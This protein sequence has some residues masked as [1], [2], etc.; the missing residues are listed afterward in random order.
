MDRE[1]EK[2]QM[3]LITIEDIFVP[4]ERKRKTMINRQIN[5]TTRKDLEIK[6]TDKHKDKQIKIGTFCKS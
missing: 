3:D 6:T 2:V 4:R 1:R 5:N